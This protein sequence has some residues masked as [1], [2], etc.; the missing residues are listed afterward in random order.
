[1]DAFA[2]RAALRAAKGVAFGVAAVGCGGMT[3]G[4]PVTVDEAG[5]VDARAVD[6]VD[7]PADVPVAAV[8]AAP[9]LDASL[10]CGAPPVSDLASL[11]A[12]A[13]HPDAGPPPVSESTFSCCL[14]GLSAD[15]QGAGFPPSDAATVDPAVTSCC[16]AVFA[17]ITYEWAAQSPLYAE[18][19]NAARLVL[20]A[21]CDTFASDGLPYPPY[22]ACDP[23][24]PPV[25]PAMPRS[26]QEVA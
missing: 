12:E 7:A 16:T 5:Q 11:L 25:P 9:A 20:S 4:E 26:A 14:S 13:E 2:F 23:W 18:D 24:G 21:C 17:R 8:D 3:A 1:M 22:P 15:L 10:A 6:A 19:G